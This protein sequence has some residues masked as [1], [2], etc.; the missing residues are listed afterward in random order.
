MES[1]TC[2][3]VE[4]IIPKYLSISQSKYNFNIIFTNTTMSITEFKHYK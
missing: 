1:V 3:N 2:V 4:L